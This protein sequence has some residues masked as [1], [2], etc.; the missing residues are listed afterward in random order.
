MVRRRDRPLRPH[1]FL[2]CLDV[3]LAHGRAGIE[4]DDSGNACCLTHGHARRNFAA[5]FLRLRRCGVM[6]ASD[7]Q[8]IDLL[9]QHCPVRRVV[10]AATADRVGEMSPGHHIVFGHDIVAFQ[11]PGLADAGLR[12]EIDDI[13]IFKARH[14]FTREI[15][16]TGDAG[17]AF[18]LRLGQILHLEATSFGICGQLSQTM[19]G[20]GVFSHQKDQHPPIRRLAS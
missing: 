8:L 18:Q 19:P 14:F 10:V 15:Q 6:T 5:G 9:R 13:G 1:L 7:D 16:Q 20:S 2:N 11:E 12:G 4:C 3:G 17:A